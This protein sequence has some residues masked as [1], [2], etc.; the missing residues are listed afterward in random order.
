MQRIISLPDGSRLLLEGQVVPEAWDVYQKRSNGHTELSFKPVIQWVE[1]DLPVPFT[2][3]QYLETLD[4][5]KRAE[6]LAEHEKELEERRLKQQKK[7]AQ[8]AK[9][10]CR[11]VI[12]SQG[13]NEML[14]L[15]Y[16][17]NQED[18]ALCKKHFKEWVRRMKVAL[19]GDFPFCASFEKQQRG[20]MHVHVACHKLPQTGV[21]R[22]QKIPA[23]RLGTEIWR[24]IIGQNNGICWVGGKTKNGGFRRNLS[25]AKL[26]AYVSKYIMKDYHESPSETNR[27]SRSDGIKL[28]KA[29]KMTFTG[30]TMQE[31]ISLAFECAESDVIVSHSVTLDDYGGGRYWLVT[32]PML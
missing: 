23:W 4:A 13:L 12:K 8:R 6:R 1:S 30:L 28:P 16:R 5:T 24:K 19:G 32:E 21:Y 3:E 9:T 25:I 22:G 2:F 17:E 27:Y 11:W 18:R 20:S 29:V 7:N 10:A 31:M 26:A 14:T 15:T